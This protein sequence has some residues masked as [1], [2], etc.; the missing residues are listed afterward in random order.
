MKFAEFLAEIHKRAG[1]LP[2]SSVNPLQEIM[3]RIWHAPYTPE[4]KA[5]RKIAAA[6]SRRSDNIEQDE[7][8]LLGK[9]AVGLVHA[10]IERRITHPC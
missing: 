3:R 6:V 10:L 7:I 8:G 2:P 9:E 5:L 4:N 1:V